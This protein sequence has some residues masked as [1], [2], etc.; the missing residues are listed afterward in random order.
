MRRLYWFV[1]M[2]VVCA[3]H[4][5]AAEAQE[6]G[7]VTG[8]V[9]D[10]ATQQPLVGAQV[11]I[12]GTQIGTLT[13]QQGRF[14]IPNVPAGQREAR[15]ILIGYASATQPVTVVAGQTAT[16]DFQLAQ[17]A[18]ALDEIVV[19]ATGETQRRRETGNVVG[20]LNPERLELAAVNNL[21]QILSARSPGVVVQQNTGVAGTSSRIRIRGSNSVSLPNQPLLI[22]DGVRVNNSATGLNTFLADAVWVGGQET[23]RWNDISPD[24]I[25]NIEIIKGPAAA[26]LY[27]TAAANGVIQITTRRG[28]IGTPQ[29]RAFT[30]H[31]TI[32][33]DYNFPANFA[34]VGRTP[35][36][37]RVAA[38][39]IDAQAR[40]LCTPVAD[41]LLSYNPLMDDTP[42]RSGN[43]QTY[44]L[45]V[46]GGMEQ[47]TYYLS[48]DFER[49]QG[50][51][52]P[53]RLRRVNLRANV[54]AQV[55]EDMNV[56]VSTG[57]VT[58]RVELPQSD[59][60]AYG[61][62]SGLLGQAV[63]DDLRRGYFSRHPSHFFFMEAGQ[64][65]GRFTGGINASWQVLP[66]LTLV[67]QA[68]L[69]QTARHD[70]E[71]AEPG[72]SDYNVSLIEGWRRSNR[73]DVRSVSGNAGGT[74]TFE[75]PNELTSTTSL[76]GAY[77]LEGIH[78]NFAF[79]RQLLTGTG[80]LGGGAAGA[81]VNEMVQDIVTLGAYVQQQFAWRDR[82]FLTAA[83]RGDDNSAFGADFEFVI[84]PSL[85]A[86]WV[87]SEED[88]FPQ[89]DFLTSLRLR[90]AYGQSGQRPGFRQATTFF[91]P[92]SVNVRGDEFTAIT[93]GGTGHALLAP[94]RSEEIE[95]G[96]DLSL[97][98][99]RLGLELTYYDKATRDALIARRLPPS[100]G[101]SP[102]RFD[103]LGRVSNRGFE[104]L[105]N[106]TLLDLG[107]ARWDVTVNASTNQNRVLELG[108]GIEPI[109]FNSEGA[110]RHTD[111][112]PLGSFFQH[113]ILGF[114]DHNGDGLI[115]R[116]NCGPGHPTL[117]LEDGTQPPCEVML[118]DTAEFLGSPFPTREL[119]LT[120]SVTLFQTLRISGQL[121]YKGGMQQYNYTRYFRCAL[122]QNCVD[123]Q[124]RNAPLEDQAAYVAAAYLGS[125]AGYIEDADFVKLRE[126]AFTFTAPQQWATR[127]GT[128]GLSLTVAGRN[129]ATWTKYTGFDPEVNSLQYAAGGAAG[130]GDFHTQDFLTIPPVRY[131][132]ARVDLRF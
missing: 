108:E 96:F 86:S 7:T 19:T 15:V 115:S 22:I 69:D 83:V 64:E 105:V 40:G 82:L 124:D 31:G 47:M 118:S 119:G 79:S 104:A 42:F 113:R 106:A 76:G 32:D 77:L 90:A 63:R 1:I 65:I 74:A 87:V 93:V 130:G 120:S 101:A 100:L 57:Y 66:W 95:A 91:T 13:N 56:S 48:G 110:Q 121:D 50:V 68:G 92:V 114:A 29:W 25:E 11:S 2:G 94:E 58:S 28:R 5:L 53:N 24:D 97:L 62:G 78:G 30:E 26:A 18:I 123:A 45:N 33:L 52:D 41:S 46:S 107:P 12:V 34:Q 117:V 39:N 4:P 98:G 43:R 75:L 35:A 3:F 84:Y 70:F 54:S 37:G 59:N 127:L 16:V 111:G 6:R 55:R 71:L 9:I 51:L 99:G 128:N 38:C 132:T 112:Y 88:F 61:W 102:T 27:G 67:G 8:T 89:T 44:G 73:F 72:I 125:V 14:L 20:T 103:N 36:G 85:S 60:N 17:A 49:E 126:L 129:L 116:L 109:I 10:A 80:T 122:W 81:S 131:W 23:T 21:S